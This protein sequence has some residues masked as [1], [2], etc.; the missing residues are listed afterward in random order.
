MM[1]VWHELTKSLTW[2]QLPPVA[3]FVC[4][5]PG[6]VIDL[7]DYFLVHWVHFQ[8]ASLP[9]LL[10]VYIWNQSKGLDW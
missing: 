1:E 3:E 2:R 7:S 8:A 9:T 6:T 5:L 10:T 4:V